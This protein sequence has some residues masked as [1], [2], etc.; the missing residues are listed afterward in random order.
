[1]LSSGVVSL[2]H[3][4]DQQSITEAASVSLRLRSA[5]VASLLAGS[6]PQRARPGRRSR[7]PM[8]WTR[9]GASPSDTM[10]VALAAHSMI[11][12]TSAIAAAK[13]TPSRR[14]CS[15]TSPS[16][17]AATSD[18]SGRRFRSSRMSDAAVQQHPAHARGHELIGST[19]SG[20][21]VRSGHTTRMQG[22][23]RGGLT[24]VRVRRTDAACAAGARC[25]E[26]ACRHRLINAGL[27][28]M[29][30]KLRCRLLCRRVVLCVLAA[31]LAVAPFAGGVAV[32]A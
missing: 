7:S 10:W 25:A 14:R 30:T 3:L 29:A 11:A 28:S 20:S 6:G 1:M 19:L 21:H 23:N 9:A 27:G 15:S 22:L 31:L 8:P 4:G 17:A 2:G 12:R 18:G 24:G 16:S 5:N 32:L 13:R 26:V